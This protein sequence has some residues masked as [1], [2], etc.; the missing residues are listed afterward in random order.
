MGLVCGIDIGSTNLKVLLLDD[1]GR[2]RWVKS[3]ATPR[4]HDDLGVLTDATGL[5][6]A[7]EG[8]II[9]GW[10]SVGG[11]KPLSAIATTGIGEDGVGVDDALKP[12]GHALA[13]FD[14]RSA[15]EAHEL[16]QSDEARNLP[17]IK[18]DFCATAGKWRWLRRHRSTDLDGA[19][20]W[21]TITDYPLAVWSGEPFISETLAV[22]T[23]CFD[24]FT[25]RWIDPLLQLSQAPPL[26]RILKAGQTVGTM[27]SGA[28]QGAGVVSPSTLI[29][30]GGHDHPLAS[31]AIRRVR[32]NARVDSLGT[33]NATYG[34]TE[35]PKRITAELGL[36]VS[37]PVMGGPGVSCFGVIEFSVALRAAI[38]D[39][40]KL[41]TLLSAASIPGALS[42]KQTGN[43]DEEKLRAALEATALRARKF[44]RAMEHCGVEHGPLFAT[45]GWARSAALMELR[46]SMFGE[47]VTV[48]DEPELTALGAALFAA[49]AAW[50]TAPNFARHHELTTILPRKDWAEA[51]ARF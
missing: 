12:L 29:V 28:L 46:A 11:G 35:N 45:G 40:K 9:E 22:R 41:R 47:P 15:A 32:A 2:T 43:T 8:L 3:V 33:A 39:D 13:W 37:V 48:I 7:L 34:E 17:A 10:V 36:D 50:G 31:S 1:E 44:F 49:E 38:P 6:A 23:G 14:K 30:A 26:P 18:L 4:L 19:K 16:S 24:V 5:V 20:C 21:I 51:Y 25:R 42:Q 27:R